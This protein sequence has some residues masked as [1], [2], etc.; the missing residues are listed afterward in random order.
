MTVKHPSGI[1]K[2]QSRTPIFHLSHCFSRYLEK[3]SD[4]SQATFSKQ[5]SLIKP[6]LRIQS[7]KCEKKHPNQKKGGGK[8]G[9]GSNNLLAKTKVFPVGD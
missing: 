6:L 3:L 5:C 8:G 1:Q 4:I 7:C 2:M 9:A